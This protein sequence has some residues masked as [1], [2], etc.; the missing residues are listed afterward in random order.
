M[1]KT[2]LINF[3][4]SSQW[5]SLHFF[6]KKVF[7]GSKFILSKEFNND[8]DAIQQM[9]FDSFNL[10]PYFWLCSN[11]FGRGGAKVALIFSTKVALQFPGMRD[12]SQI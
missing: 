6:H 12:A 5:H 1:T 3:E 4:N 2:F 10:D 9:I 7:V 11:I 8:D